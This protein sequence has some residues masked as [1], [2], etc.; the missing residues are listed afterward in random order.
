[1]S[2]IHHVQMKYLIAALAHRDTA[3]FDDAFCGEDG[4]DALCTYWGQLGRRLAPADR[5]SSNGSDVR[6]D[7]AGPDEALLFTFPPALLPGEAH[8]LMV[9]PTSPPRVFALEETLPR[10]GT[11]NTVLVELR[12][13]ERMNHGPGPIPELRA[14]ARTVWRLLDTP[15]RPA[16]VSR[17]PN[18]FMER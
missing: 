14:F 8:F 10:S 11:T 7:T 16:L 9:L 1:L 2:R 4:A 18:P 6:W 12:A 5:I 3:R 15:A 17:L 13:Q